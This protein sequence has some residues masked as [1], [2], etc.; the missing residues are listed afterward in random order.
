MESNWSPSHAHHFSKHKQSKFR[1]SHFVQRSR[2]SGNDV[3]EDDTSLRVLRANVV[4]YALEAYTVLLKVFLEKLEKGSFDWR[5]KGLVPILIV[6][7]DCRATKPRNTPTFITNKP[8]LNFETAILFNVVESSGNQVCDSENPT[9]SHSSQGKGCKLYP[10]DIYGF[11]RKYCYRNFKKHSFNWKLKWLVPFLIVES[12]GKA[13]NTPSKPTIS[14]MTYNKNFVIAILFY[15]VESSGNY[16]F[17]QDT[18]S[19]VFRAR[20]IK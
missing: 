1:V 15:T 8:N 5:F 9:S 20:V 7:W 19:T 13:T 17:K 18:P 12:D 14:P 16:V 6:E 11:Y 2:S 10:G 3:F 4:S